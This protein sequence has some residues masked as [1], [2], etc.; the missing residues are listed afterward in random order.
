M[1][2][3]ASQNTQASPGLST[4]TWISERKLWRGEQHTESSGLL[5]MQ[6]SQGRTCHRKLEKHTLELLASQDHDHRAQIYP[7]KCGIRAGKVSRSQ[8]PKDYPCILHATCTQEQFMMNSSLY[9]IVAGKKDYYEW[10]PPP[11]PAE[12]K[13]KVQ[14]ELRWT[15]WAECFICR[16][17]LRQLLLALHELWLWD[18]EKEA[19]TMRACFTGKDLCSEEELIVYDHW[20][21]VMDKQIHSIIHPQ[22]CCVVF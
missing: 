3:S 6:S 10:Y 15:I 5:V 16:S 2:T 21:W 13:R 22:H 9:T 14:V 4:T 18:P 20:S 1:T 17:K 8:P 12:G 19:I 7:H 11:L